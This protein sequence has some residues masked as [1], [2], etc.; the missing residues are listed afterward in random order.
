[1]CWVPRRNSPARR[2]YLEDIDLPRG[3]CWEHTLTFVPCIE[4]IIVE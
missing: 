1:M 2:S 3:V 4:G